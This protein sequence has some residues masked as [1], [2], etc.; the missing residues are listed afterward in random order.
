ML[1]LCRLVLVLTTFLEKLHFTWGT[2][3]NL[4]KNCGLR[5]AVLPSTLWE[6][7]LLTPNP[8]HLVAEEI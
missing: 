6:I 5:E 8:C 2:N 1:E 7:M 4:G 3:W